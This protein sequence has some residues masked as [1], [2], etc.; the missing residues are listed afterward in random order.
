M[1]VQVGWKHAEA[2]SELEAARK[3]R[4]NVFYEKKKK[5]ALARAKAAAKVAA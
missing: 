2:V 1:C 3:E 4:S 5:D